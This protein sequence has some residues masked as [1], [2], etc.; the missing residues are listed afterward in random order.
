MNLQW[1]HIPRHWR[2]S[3]A[4]LMQPAVWQGRTPEWKNMIRRRKCCLPSWQNM[5]R[6]PISHLMRNCMLLWQTY[7]LRIRTITRH[8][9]RYSAVLHGWIV[10]E[11]VFRTIM[12]DISGWIRNPEKRKMMRRTERMLWRRMFCCR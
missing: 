2:L 6:R 4:I 10:M 9:L 8:L 3:P 11:M 1:R 5:K 7:T 12:R